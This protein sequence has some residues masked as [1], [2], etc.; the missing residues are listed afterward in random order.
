MQSC[1]EQLI[2]AGNEAGITERL[3]MRLELLKMYRLDVDNAVA[4]LV[5]HG[6]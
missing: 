4:M 5:H 2:E 3:E 6:A 1:K